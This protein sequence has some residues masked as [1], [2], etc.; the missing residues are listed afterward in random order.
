[1]MEL[2]LNNSLIQ[3]KQSFTLIHTLKCSEFSEQ[4]FLDGTNWYGNKKTLKSLTI[5]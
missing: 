2:T 4:L 5:S 1:M 3:I